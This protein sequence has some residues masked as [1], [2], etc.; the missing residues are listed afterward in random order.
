M[1]AREAAS[2][3]MQATT[4]AGGHPLL[5]PSLLGLTGR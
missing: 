2:A 4:R 5:P 3:G 1:A